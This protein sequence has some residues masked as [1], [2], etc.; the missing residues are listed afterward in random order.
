MSRTPLPPGTRGLVVEYAS[1]TYPRSRFAVGR[2]SAAAPLDVVIAVLTAEIVVVIQG[3]TPGGSAAAPP[4][5]VLVVIVTG[6]GATFPWP[7]GGSAAAPPPDGLVDVM[8]WVSSWNDPTSTPT[9][10]IVVTVTDPG[11]ATIPDMGP[12]TDGITIPATPIN[13]TV[14]GQSP[15]IALALEQDHTAR[16]AAGGSAT[17]QL[18]N[19]QRILM[20]TTAT[21]HCPFEP[22][23]PGTSGIGSEGVSTCHSLAC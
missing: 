11:N 1:V 18:L 23:L 21:T 8:A 5:G 3:T 20:S 13:A 14:L 12:H 15:R 6:K 16:N 2:G 9:G 10:F 22:H 17:R 19:S 4:V 7:G